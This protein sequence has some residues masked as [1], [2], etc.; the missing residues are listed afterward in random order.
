MAKEYGN[1]KDEMLANAKILTAED[2]LIMSADV[3]EQAKSLEIPVH[4]LSKVIFPMVSLK[5]QERILKRGSLK[6]KVALRR[7]RLHDAESAHSDVPRSLNGDLLR[8]NIKAELQM[9]R[10]GVP[11]KLRH[12]KAKLQSDIHFAYAVN[13]EGV[14]KD[15]RDLDYMNLLSELGETPKNQGEQA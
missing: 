11:K 5:R 4:D 6:M 10:V 1:I 12:P 13:S 7:A 3:Y 9:L 2:G 14:K 8:F 15:L